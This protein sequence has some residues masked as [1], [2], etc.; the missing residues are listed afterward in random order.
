MR[1]EAVG[2]AQHGNREERLSALAG[3]RSLWS[4]IDIEE[5]IGL[6][7]G[8][9]DPQHLPER[10]ASRPR[11]ATQLTPGLPR[12][13]EWQPD[14]RAD[15]RVHGCSDGVVEL[16]IRASEELACLCV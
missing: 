7:R 1:L 16:R 12:N 5:E 6:I 4:E 2:L 13:R 3:F 10:G 15:V 8:H 9:L 11:A 14:R